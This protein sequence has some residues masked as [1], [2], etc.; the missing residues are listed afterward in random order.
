MELRKK[1]ASY[2]VK[3]QVASDAG[4]G[5]HTYLKSDNIIFLSETQVR[6]R[7]SY[8][9][10]P[11]RR[12]GSSFMDDLTIYLNDRSEMGLLFNNPEFATKAEDYEYKAKTQYILKAI[13][14][15]NSNRRCGWNYWVKR[16]LDQNGY[17]SIITYFEYK[18]DGL[19][20]QIS[21]H[22]P[23]SK[24]PVELDKMANG[25]KGRICHWDHGSSRKNCQLL[26]DRFEF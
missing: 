23:F 1:I 17:S 20:V 24:S 19:K 6:H 12:D 4:K 26:I 14:L 16:T 13:R 2:V 18:N 8:Q 22:T 9:R 25:K 11:D 7:T 15:I 10:D 5:A 21:F 3:A